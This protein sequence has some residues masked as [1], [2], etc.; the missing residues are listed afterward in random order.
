MVEYVMVPVP[1]EFADDVARFVEYTVSMAERDAV[2]E[3]AIARAIATLDEPLRSFLSYI[4]EATIKGG[5]ATVP[6]LRAVLGCSE[7][8]VLGTMLE[9]NQRMRI[10]GAPLALLPQKAPGAPTSDPKDQVVLMAEPAARAVAAAMSDAAID[11]P[12]S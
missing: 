11:G 3:D 9:V 2:A 4:A 7:R 6:R 10:A 12:G 5:L 1:V 8:E